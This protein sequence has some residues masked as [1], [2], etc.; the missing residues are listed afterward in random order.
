MAV[1]VGNLDVHFRGRV[2]VSGG[3]RGDTAGGPIVMVLPRYERFVSR[4]SQGSLR[5]AVV[6]AFSDGELHTDVSE[7]VEGRPCDVWV[8]KRRTA[9]GVDGT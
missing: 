9:A 4:L 6:R 8:R 2:R 1:G 5:R 7:Q 3:R